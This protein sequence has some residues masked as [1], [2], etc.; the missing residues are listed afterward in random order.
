[1]KSN[2][3]KSLQIMQPVANVVLG[4]LC[5]YHASPVPRYHVHLCPAILTT[6]LGPNLVRPYLSI[7]VCNSSTASKMIVK[8]SPKLVSLYS[9]RGGISGYDV[10]ST[11]PKSTSLRRQSFSTL[12]VRPSKER[13]IAPGR[14]TSWRIRF[15]MRAD[16]LHAKIL[17]VIAAADVRFF[18]AF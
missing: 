4:F 15:R 13:V 11:S 1:M 10:R 14:F 3:A 16:H 8:R 5:F 7:M 6:G 17:S 18:S 9:T 12:V 2:V